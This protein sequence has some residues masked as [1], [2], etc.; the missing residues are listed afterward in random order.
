MASWSLVQ[1]K[2]IF[3]STLLPILQIFYKDRYFVTKIGSQMSSLARISAGVP[4]G[5][6]SSPTLY[7]L[8]SADQPTT[9]YTSVADFADD[10]IIYST[11]KD[12]IIAGMNLQNHLDL[13]SSWYDKWKIKI[14]HEKSTHLTFKL[15][16]GTVP[17]INLNNQNI[18]KSSSSRYLGLFLDQ[19]LTWADHIKKKKILLNSRRKSLQFL[20]GKHSKLNLKTKLLLYKTLLMPIWTYGIQLWGAAK[21]SNTNK[22]QTFQSTTL[23]IITNAPFYVSNHT[24]HT[25]LKI[26]TIEETAKII[27]KRF[28]SRLTNH[29]NPLISALD[30]DTI[31]GNPPRRLKRK[32]C[33]DL[34]TN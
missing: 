6:V 20:L 13:I 23:R 1:I 21:K 22:I 12:P 34:N 9:P 27:Y 18:P 10:K 15:K 11:H 8:Y 14:N 17:P 7:N 16:R 4:Q 19:R 33:R 25:D 32:W 31:P 3:T 26:N 30:S 28:R 29:S 2:K 24:L 5:A